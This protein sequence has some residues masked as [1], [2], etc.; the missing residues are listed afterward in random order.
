METNSTAEQ[1]IFLYGQIQ[2]GQT[3]QIK[4]DANM[5]IMA[6]LEGTQAW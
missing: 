5:K 3:R 6:F 2:Y 1:I 4:G